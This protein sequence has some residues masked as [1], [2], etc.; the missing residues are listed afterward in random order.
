MHLSPS[1]LAP[2]ILFSPWPQI[3]TLMQTMCNCD[4]CYLWRRL[5]DVDYMVM[6]TRERFPEKITCELKSIA[7]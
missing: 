5:S 6:D 3:F 1:W 2:A 7:E 4:K